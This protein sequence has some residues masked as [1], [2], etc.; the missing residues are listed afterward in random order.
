MS[1]TVPAVEW[2]P[3]NTQERKTQQDAILPSL[4]AEQVLRK[5]L[6]NRLARIEGHVRSVREM[7][8][9]DRPSRDLVL[10]VQAI[11]A[12]LNQFALTLLEHELKQEMH[13][14]EE[15]Q[16]RIEELIQTLKMLL[17]HA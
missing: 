3:L 13:L 1:V 6:T 5:G 10:Q 4:D 14:T 17:K 2:I 12:A 16:P 7:V 15:T 8:L 9:Q 11:K